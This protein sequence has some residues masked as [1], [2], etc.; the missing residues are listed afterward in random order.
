[1]RKFSMIE[2]TPLY[3]KRYGFPFAL[4]L[5]LVATDAVPLCYRHVASPST[6]VGAVRKG[7]EFPAIH[8]I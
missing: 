7:T 1:M 4:D 2:L 5:L 8:N 6:N 3:L